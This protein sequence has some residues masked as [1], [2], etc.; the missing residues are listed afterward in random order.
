MAGRRR[1]LSPT[2]FGGVTR[3]L[4]FAPA[5][6]KLSVPTNDRRRIFWNKLPPYPIALERWRGGDRA[7]QKFPFDAVN[8]RQPRALST[9]DPA[10]FLHIPSPAALYGCYD[11]GGLRTTYLRLLRSPERLSNDDG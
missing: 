8:Q 5:N 6:L 10:T 11:S 3:A 1:R 9:F 4:D 2:R 7:R